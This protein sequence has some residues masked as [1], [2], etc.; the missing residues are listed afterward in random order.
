MN[1]AYAAYREFHKTRYQDLMNVIADHVPKGSQRLVDIGSGGD[2]AGL[3]ETIKTGYTEEYHTVDLYGDPAVLKQKGIIG[4]KANVDKNPLPF[5]DQA[6]DAVLFASVVEHLYNP[7]FAI[8]EMARIL[9]TDG[10]L[11]LEAPNAVALGRRL[12]TLFGENPFHRF[13]QYNALEN[14]A[15][16]EYC[17]VF[18]TPDEIEVLLSPWFIVEECR[19]SMHNPPSG[20]FKRLIRNTA[21]RFNERFSDCFFI[22]AKKKPHPTQS[23]N[24]ASS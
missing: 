11:I 2:A 4:H 6:V 17:S 20:F 22:V 7:H 8:S 14:K 9:K 10:V 12:D 18:Y 5:E 13:N 24:T 3:V 1:D 19:H 21:V 23:P 16:M 15:I